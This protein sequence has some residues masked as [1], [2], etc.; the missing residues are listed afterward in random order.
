M[1][2]FTYAVLL[3]VGC[4]F[5]VY[6]GNLYEAGTI[7]HWQV[8]IAILLFGVSASLTNQFLRSQRFQNW[9]AWRGF[10]PIDRD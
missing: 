8:F 5:G 10:K 6:L 1:D 4:L 9:W 2:N 3:I 7:A